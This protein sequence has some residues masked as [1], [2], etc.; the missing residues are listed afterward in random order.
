MTPDSV[1]TFA[2]SMDLFWLVLALAGGAF[3]AMIGPNFAFAFTGVSILV[4]FA[5]AAT[6][7]STI[8]LDYVAF[9]PVF[10]PHIAFAG[11]VGAASYAARKGLLPG[12]GRDINSPLAGLGRPDVLVVGALYGVGG[13]VLHKLIVL[14]P[15]FGGH[16]DSVALTVVTS[17]IVARIMFGKTPVFHAPTPPEGTTRWLDWQEKPLQLLTVSGFASLFASGVA[18]MLVGYIAPASA[19]PQA[20]INNAQ[21]V[22]FAFSALCIFFVAMGMRW[23]VTHHMTITAGLAAVVFFQ[24]TGSG[25]TAVAIG[26]VFG[27]IA[28]FGGELLARLFYA[29]GDTHI[30]PPAGI[31]WIMNTAVVSTAALFS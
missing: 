12:G 2:S 26:T 8:Y 18:A 28:G 9:G 3:A 21:V 16:T 23:P 7:G 24:I 30:D 4:G 15:W 14:I 13:Y 11:G 19:N 17:G 29:H 31:I 5:V 1:F 6:T 27:I 22:P 20:I 25:L 10:G